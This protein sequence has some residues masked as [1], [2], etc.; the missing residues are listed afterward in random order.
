[1]IPTVLADETD[2]SEY[3]RFP[4]NKIK[5]VYKKISQNKYCKFE[6]AHQ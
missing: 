3:E 2:F 4:Q 6:L 5:V 1:V